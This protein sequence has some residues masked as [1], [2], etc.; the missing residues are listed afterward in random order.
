MYIAL[1]FHLYL[2]RLLFTGFRFVKKKSRVYEYLF[3]VS[4]DIEK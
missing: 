2:C 3:L 1:Y 4:L